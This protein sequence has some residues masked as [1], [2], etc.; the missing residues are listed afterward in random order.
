[1]NLSKYEIKLTS[2]E[3]KWIDSICDKY[4]VKSKA[5]RVIIASMSKCL[6]YCETHQTYIH[7]Y[8]LNSDSKLLA[9]AIR[10]L[11]H[12]GFLDNSIDP[13]LNNMSDKD[14]YLDIVLDHHNK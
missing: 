2:I 4:K 6:S 5:E 13:C 3:V 11:R 12:K 8:I 9:K 7:D 1:M 14:I 10:S